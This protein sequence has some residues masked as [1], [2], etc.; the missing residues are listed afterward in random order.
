MT[1]EYRTGEQAP[2]SGVYGFVRH[3]TE[4][5]P[6]CVPTPAEQEIPLSKGERFPPH[7]SCGQGV[8]WRLVRYA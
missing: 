4:R 2:V 1:G 6:R 8:V 3:I 5:F 7:K